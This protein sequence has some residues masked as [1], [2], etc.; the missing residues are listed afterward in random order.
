MRCDDGEVEVEVE[1][2]PE[3]QFDAKHSVLE[4]AEA[5]PER[6]SAIENFSRFFLSNHVQPPLFWNLRARIR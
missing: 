6:A 3:N 2:E 1:G 5:K 4:S